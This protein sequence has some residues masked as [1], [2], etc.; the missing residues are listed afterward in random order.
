M[1][2]FHQWIIELYK[3]LPQLI[4]LDF[5]LLILQVYKIND[6]LELVSSM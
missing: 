2:I 6:Q 5:F 1:I 4:A 3:Y